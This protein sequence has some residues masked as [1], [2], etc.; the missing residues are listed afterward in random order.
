MR[1]T[2]NAGQHGPH[3]NLRTLRP[4]QR[5][6]KD[7]CWG[8]RCSAPTMRPTRCR[9]MAR[10]P[11]LR[12]HRRTGGHRLASWSHSLRCGRLSNRLRDG[13]CDW[14]R[15]ASSPE[16]LRAARRQPLWRSRVTRV[17]WIDEAGCCDAEQ[18]TLC[19]SGCC[20]RVPW[21]VGRSAL[22][23][24]RREEDAVR[25]QRSEPRI[26]PTE[27]VVKLSRPE[28]ASTRVPAIT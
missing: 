18:N 7:C 19:R 25:H 17:F 20:R 4:H 5:K 13:L 15:P 3:D 24:G 9:Q 27:T 11:A 1:Y 10:M 2:I 16:E 6:R 26:T 23:I 14:Q 22:H 8:A 21:G 12:R 28:C